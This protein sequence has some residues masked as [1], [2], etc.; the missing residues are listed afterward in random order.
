LGQDSEYFGTPLHAAI[1]GHRNELAC[2]IIELMK[3]ENL[4]EPRNC[5]KAA[6]VSRS[7]SM[8]QNLIDHAQ[9]IILDERKSGMPVCSS[10]SF[11]FPLPQTFFFQIEVFLSSIIIANLS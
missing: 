8:L 7:L 4:K 11:P 6:V 10:S 1:K 3:K 5:F 9:P 2:I